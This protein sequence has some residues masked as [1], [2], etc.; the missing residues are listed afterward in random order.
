M[1][2]TYDSIKDTPIVKKISNLSKKFPYP[3]LYCISVFLLLEKRNPDSKWKHYI[4]VFP[5][6]FN[7]FPLFYTDEEFKEL[8][9][10]PI[11]DKI[12]NTN[13]EQKNNFDSM[14]KVAPELSKFTFQEF[15]E[16]MML[17]QSR[18][19][20]VTLNGKDRECMAPLADMFNHKNQKTAKWEYSDTLN[21]FIVKA[22]ENIKQGD[23]V[24]SL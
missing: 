4:N 8:E 14:L 7:Y 22:T 20:G 6:G 13:V 15:K 11:I 5:R 18:L 16:M 17:V 1:I 19:F 24:N 10:S 23:E 3:Q 12:K 9:G 21:N 2:I